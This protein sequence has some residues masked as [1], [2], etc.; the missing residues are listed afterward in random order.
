MAK[1][2]I[3][4]ASKSELTKLPGVGAATAQKII[5][6]REFEQPFTSVD[7]LLK[8]SGISQGLVDKIRDEVTIGTTTS[9]SD[10]S[11][12][13]KKSKSMSADKIDSIM[14][15]FD[16]EPKVEEV[17]QEALKYAHINDGRFESWI[18]RAKNQAWLPKIYVKGQVRKKNKDGYTQD[19]LVLGSFDGQGVTVEDQSYIEAKA[20]FDLRELVFH[21]DELRVNK[22]ILTSVKDR[23]KLLEYITKLYFDRRK[24]QIDL[25][26]NP[27]RSSKGLLN[28]KMKIMQETSILNAL[29][30]GYFSKNTK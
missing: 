28:A 17:Q 30:N 20:E 3:N 23:K 14:K 7:D 5:N 1:V 8:V 13:V 26:L 29:T 12:R 11:G 18:S 24:N 19:E 6:Y 21:P 22:E 10:N 25:V 4:N 9:S 15:K 27:P 16:N 2:D